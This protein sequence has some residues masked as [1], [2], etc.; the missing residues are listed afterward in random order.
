MDWISRNSHFAFS[1]YSSITFERYKIRSN[2]SWCLACHIWVV[3]GILSDK[4][5]LYRQV[6]GFFWI[7]CLIFLCQHRTFDLF[8]LIHVGL[9]FTMFDEFQS[10]HLHRSP[11]IFHYASVTSGAAYD[12]CI[13]NNQTS[14]MS[15][16][17]PEYRWNF[18]RIICFIWAQEN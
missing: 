13:H 9:L 3:C 5:C 7:Y 4:F 8:S 6:S 12:R 11:D 18:G 17:A 10:G 1:S 16:F 2:Y 14:H 15:Q